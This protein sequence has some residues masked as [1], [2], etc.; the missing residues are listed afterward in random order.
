MFTF[1]NVL[2]M[3]NRDSADF[4]KKYQETLQNI[5][6][7]MEALKAD[8]KKAEKE[9]RTSKVKRLLNSIKKYKKRVNELENKSENPSIAG[10]KVSLFHF[11][12]IVLLK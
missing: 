2:Q 7:K 9:G 1:L 8:K 6:F 5:K 11:N 10:E 4:F 3:L 12:Y